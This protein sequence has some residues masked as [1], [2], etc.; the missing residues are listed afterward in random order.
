VN[1]TP[2]LID[3]LVERATPVRRLRPPL[4]RAAFWLV[5]AGLVLALTAIGHGLRPDLALR[6]H[7]PS[8]AIGTASAL[9]TGILSAMAAFVIS[10]PGRSRWWLALPIP[11]LAAWISTLGYG[12]LTDWVSVGPDGVRLSDELRCFALLVLTSVPLAVVLAVMLRYAA[13]LR[14]GTVAILG[15]LA[16]ASITAAALSLFHDHDAT[17]IVLVW[18]LG[19]AV[20]ITGIGGALG[21]HIRLKPGY[22]HI[23]TAR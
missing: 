5:F 2:E 16:I 20:L 8:F 4:V 14:A 18:N 17:A 6:L 3:A 23:E 22:P 7:Q 1:E 12:C 15:G 21:R 10:V 13:T 9:A 19:T 11:P